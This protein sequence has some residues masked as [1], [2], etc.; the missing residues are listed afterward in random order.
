MASVWIKVRSVYETFSPRKTVVTDAVWQ[1]WLVVPMPVGSLDEDRMEDWID[2]DYELDFDDPDN[3]GGWLAEHELARGRYS[4][5][6]FRWEDGYT[7]ETMETV[8][9]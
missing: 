2:A 4:H 3:R 9:G 8:N 5:G 6:T 7:R 1:I